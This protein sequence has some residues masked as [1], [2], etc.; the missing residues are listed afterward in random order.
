MDYPRPFPPLISLSVFV[1]FSLL[2]VTVHPVYGQTST[3]DALLRDSLDTAGTN[4]AGFARNEACY[5]ASDLT[6]SLREPANG[7]RFEEPGD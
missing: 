4:C 7:E 3:C 2:V 6:T 5:G 1:F